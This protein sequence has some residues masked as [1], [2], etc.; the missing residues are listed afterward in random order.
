MTPEEQQLISGLFERMR[1]LGPIDKDRDA[2]SF[3]MQSVLGTPDAAYKLVQSVLVQEQALE[4]ATIRNQELEQRIQQLEHGTQQ[5]ARASGGFLGG[6]FG[7]A[8]PSQP[9]PQPARPMAV[10]AAGSRPYSPQQASS[11][12]GNQGQQPM[13]Q[14]PMQQPAQNTGGGFMKTAMVTAAGVAGGML[15]AGAIGNMLGGPAKAN[16]GANEGHGLGSTENT[17]TDE[18]RQQEIAAQDP[19]TY[20][21]NSSGATDDGGGWFGGDDGGDT[22]F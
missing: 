20:D 2:E 22:E 10:P 4:E 12:W 1:A 17:L 19:G 11:P 6:L 13:Y 8:K 9:P 7:G 21:D 14:Q 16:T 3:I 15:V 5:P 18:P